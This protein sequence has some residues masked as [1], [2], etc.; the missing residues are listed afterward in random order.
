MLGAA[1]L[2]VVRIF[3][4]SLPVVLSQFLRCP[5]P[6]AEGSLTDG[7]QKF[8]ARKASTNPT[9]SSS[10]HSAPYIFPSTT[11]E[12]I[13]TVHGAQR[14][15]ALLLSEGGGNEKERKKLQARY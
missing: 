11:H 10:S 1:F 9:G 7:T 4:S 5:F 2:K 3:L 8:V 13:P 6:T 14:A 12:M 15:R